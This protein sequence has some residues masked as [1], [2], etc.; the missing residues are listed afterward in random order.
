MQKPKIR[1]RA[2]GFKLVKQADFSPI[3]G[4]IGGLRG[5]IGRILSEIR[6]H[7]AVLGHRPQIYADLGGGAADWR[8]FLGGFGQISGCAAEWIMAPRLPTTTILSSCARARCMRLQSQ[9]LPPSGGTW[10]AKTC[11]LARYW[12][13][14]R[15]WGGGFAAGTRLIRLTRLTGSVA[16]PAEAPT[17]GRGGTLLTVL[18][19]L[20]GSGGDFGGWGNR[21]VARH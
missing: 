5:E 9:D 15:C 7:G 13:E 17:E 4:G 12:R 20:T 18:T 11:A 14:A 21:A 16:E 19:V 2:E 8:G 1:R 10:G 3:S 6:P